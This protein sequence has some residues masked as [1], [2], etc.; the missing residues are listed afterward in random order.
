M[1]ETTTPTSYMIFKSLL[2]ADTAVQW[3]NR[4]A[5]ILSLFMPIVILISWKNIVESMGGAFAL[6]SCITIGLIA[7][8]I[9][10]YTNTIAR[11][12][13]KGV[14][15]RLRVTPASPTI[16]MTSR[17]VVQI[18]Q[19]SIMTILVFIVAYFLDGITLSTT[20]YILS[21]IISLFCGAVFLSLGQAIVGL[22]SSAEIVNSVSRFVYIGLVLIGAFGE[23]GVLGGLLKNIIL[24]SPYGAVK[25]LLL[26]SMVPSQWDAKSWLALG[27]TILYIVIFT[28][29]GIK[30]FKWRT[31]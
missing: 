12:R 31:N 2:R 19:I 28:M 15:E 8:G 7:V 5:S 16:I 30:W 6:S 22:I 11:D 26:A 27:V 13:E 18:F 24:L 14:F 29:I 20:G 21:F 23:L 4:R 1:T 9:M 17:I 25:I 10:G 3:R